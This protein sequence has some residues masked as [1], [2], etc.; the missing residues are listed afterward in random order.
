MRIIPTI[1]E[2]IWVRKESSWKKTKVFA[3]TE[4]PKIY[5]GEKEIIVFFFITAECDAF[6]RDTFTYFHTHAFGVHTLNVCERIV[7]ICAR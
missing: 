2:S 4:R 3:P 1:D 6:A 5:S 7:Y